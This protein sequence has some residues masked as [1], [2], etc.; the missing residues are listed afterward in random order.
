MCRNESRSIQ[1]Q[2]SSREKEG[3]TRVQGSAG[4][5]EQNW[6]KFERIYL[7]PDQEQG[8]GLFFCR[9][10]FFLLFCFVFFCFF[11]SYFLFF[12]L[13]F[14]LFLFFLSSWDLFIF[15][16]LS[17][18]V[19][20]LLKRRFLF[21]L[22][23]FCFLFVLFPVPSDQAYEKNELLSVLVTIQSLPITTWC[24]SPPICAQHAQKSHLCHL[25]K[26]YA[27]QIPTR[28]LQS[29]PLINSFM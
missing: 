12:V 5:I 15:C 17:C 2:I 21:F 22:F 24:G 16:L 23:V 27:Q 3:E 6:P 26:G 11:F 13:F 10:L 28:P 7:L 8:I 14:V 25:S 1:G 19:F 20:F 9:C 4:S 29:S 18:F